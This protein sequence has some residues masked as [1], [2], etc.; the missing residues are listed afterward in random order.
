M[1]LDG[2]QLEL[3]WGQEPGLLAR[4]LDLRG[5]L[6][7]F[8]EFGRDTQTIEATLSDGTNV[9]VF[10]NE[11]WTARQRAAHSLHEI[12]YR[13]CF[14]PQL[15]AFFIQRLTDPGDIVY[16]PFSGR[17]T[18]GLEAALRG[19]VP[20]FCD[21][22]PLSAIL[23]RPRI[24][25]PTQRDVEARLAEMDF[26][27]DAPA[28]EELK[29]FFHSDTLREVAALRLTFMERA[30]DGTLDR[31]DQWIRM[32]ATNRLTGHSP[33]FFSV[34][35]LPPNQA[36]SVKSQQRINER[37]G[38]SPP[39]RHV[40]DL[41]AR[42]SGQLLSGLEAGERAALDSVQANA[43]FYT[44]SAESTPEIADATVSLIVTSPPFL[45]IVDYAQDNW[46][47][48]W[49]CGID[50]A[51]IGVWQFKKLEAWQSAM[52]QTLRELRRIL[53]PGGH[54]AFEVGEVRKGA[55]QLETSV[56]DAGRQA[57]LEPLAVMINDQD[58]T[59]TAHIWGVNN[60]TSGT[61]TNRIVVFRKDGV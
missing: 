5:A 20:Y 17:G 23:S 15:P 28:P 41:I 50:A 8:R 18:T 16:D 35:T 53:K 6:K 7:S 55:V 4:C 48:G 56:M 54:I 19:R 26:T 60:K 44:A 32:V 43:R 31:V 25:P 61:N 1:N 52:T 34:Y 22:N 9:P 57:D 58:F 51:T 36:A 24:Q 21:I 38:Q 59:K 2:A 27:R 37:L 45:D 12:S 13:A 11:F 49:F 47:R 33:G 3:H 29:V 46:L 14:K 39:H 42:K 10:V 30:A 40:A